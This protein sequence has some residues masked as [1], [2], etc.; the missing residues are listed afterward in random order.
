MSYL[1]VKWVKLLLPE[2]VQSKTIGNMIQ[3]MRKMMKRLKRMRT[4]RMILTRWRGS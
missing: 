3:M 2:L 4:K 1:V